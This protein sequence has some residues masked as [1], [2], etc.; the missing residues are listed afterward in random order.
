MKKFLVI[1]LV[2]LITFVGVGLFLKEFFVVNPAPSTTGELSQISL[3]EGFTITEYAKV[4]NARSMVL[5][6]AGILYVG[7]RRGDS[8][9]AV[10]DN[11]DDGIGDEVLTIAS[12]LFMPNGVDIL[13]GDLYVAEVD[14]IIRFDNIDSSVRNPPVPVVVYDDLP[15]DEWHGWKFI[16]FGPD[17]KL[18]VPVGAPCNVCVREAPYSRMLRMN[19][20]GSD[21]ETYFSGM[22]N[23][24]GFDWHPQTKELWWTDNGRDMWGDDLP[25]DELNHAPTQGMH[26]GFPYCHGSGLVDDEFN[27]VGTCDNYTSPV[28]DLG[29]HVAA[30]GMEFYTADQFPS[31]WKQGVFI[32]E[33]GSWNRKEPIGYRV[34]F[35]GLEGDGSVSYEPFAS[36]WLQDGKAWGRPVDLE[37]MPDG[38]LLV[39]DDHHGAIYKISYTG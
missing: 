24:V 39:S 7:N 3:P 19:P 14:K 21:V 26:Y 8:V 27:T 32:A 38:S 25:P 15:D 10:L 9:Y 29:P 30:L 12:D 18:Y 34:T 22:R 20:D 6:D 4:P 35:V 1:S 2:I 37:Q 11:N 23:S 33:H 16:K 28:Q 17:E 5:S 13:D 36:G 31:S